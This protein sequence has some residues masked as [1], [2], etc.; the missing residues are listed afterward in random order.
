MQARTLGT[1][2]LALALSG[3]GAAGQ[4]IEGEAISVVFDD[5]WRKFPAY[6]EGLTL[7]EGYNRDFGYG[8]VRAFMAARMHV[9]R[10]CAAGGE[11][12]G[13][14]TD[15]SGFDLRQCECWVFDTSADRPGVSTCIARW[16]CLTGA[17]DE[18]WG[19]RP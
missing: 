16:R 14:R 18:R 13:R 4:A 7:P 8:C 9:R 15:G 17:P 19:E 11:V 5:E 6:V 2:A 12:I 10:S 3:V 1:L